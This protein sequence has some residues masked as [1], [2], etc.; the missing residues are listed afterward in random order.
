[1]QTEMTTTERIATIELASTRVIFRSEVVAQEYNTAVNDLLHRNSF[2]LSGVYGPYTVKLGM[3][4]NRLVLH[5]RGT[6]GEQIQRI[7][8]TPLKLVIKDYFIIC[9]QYYSAQRDAHPSRLEAIDMARRGIHNEGA[10]KLQDMLAPDITVDFD[11]ARRLFTLI[12]VLHI[13]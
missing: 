4:E 9:E 8:I 6:K 12:C 13:R 11:T 5:I 1:M 7:P 3:A 2:C 10:E